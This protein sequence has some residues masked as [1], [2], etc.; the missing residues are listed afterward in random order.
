MFP[1][2][3]VRFGRLSHKDAHQSSCRTSRLLV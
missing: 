1:S 3:G 2:A